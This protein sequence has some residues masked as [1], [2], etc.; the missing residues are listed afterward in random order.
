MFSRVLFQLEFRRSFKSL[1]A[2]SLSI[3][4][5]MVFVIVL[6]PMV[7]DMYA[8]IPAEYMSVLDSFGG[9]PNNILEYYATEGVMMLQLFGG[10]YA[11]LEG[12]GAINRDDKEKVVE[13]IYQL[14][15]KRRVFFITKWIRVV[16]NVLLFSLINYL[17]SIVSFA[18]MKESIDQTLFLNFNLLNTLLF[19]IM[20][21]LGYALACFIK[22]TPKSMGALAI[23]L[24]LYIVSV[25]SSMTDNKFL[26]KLKYITPF[27]FADPVAL[28]K[29][30]LSVEWVIVLVFTAISVL[31]FVAAY[32]RFQKRQF[33][34]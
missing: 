31:L 8:S 14:P 3:G 24:L 7:K 27:S 22:A 9:V 12:F 18:I 32:F 1:L 4:L 15:Y 28:M 29:E 13:S 6:Y 23:P 2:W 33:T 11:V 16:V 5:T 26:D 21:L 34:I 30:G 19:L 10:I 25:I 20:A 17:L